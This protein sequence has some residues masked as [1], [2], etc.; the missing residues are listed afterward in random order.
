MKLS[1]V[2]C[3]YNCKAEYLESCVRSIR[4]STLDECDYEILLIDDG[5]EIDYTDIIDKYSLRCIKTE[6]GG[7]LAARTLGVRSVAGEY[8]TF[9]DSDDTVSV[10]Y[11]RPMLE[12]LE[13]EGADIVYNDWAFHSARVRHLCNRDKTISSDISCEDEDVLAM[14]TRCGGRQHSFYVLWNKMYKTDLLLR[15][16]NE[17]DR[18]APKDRKYNYSEDALINFFAHK[19]AKKARNL[20]T[21]YY[22]YRIH[23]TQSVVVGTREKLLLQIENMA[24]TLG[25]MR[26]N[27]GEH[28][29]R[30]RIIHDIREWELMMSRAHYSHALGLGFS[31]LYKTI[32]EKYNVDKL[33]RAT[34]KDGDVYIGSRVIAS[35]IDEIDECLYKIWS[36]GESGISSVGLSRYTLAVLDYMRN[37]GRNISISNCGGITIPRE[38]IS[39]KRRIIHSYPVSLLGMLLFPKGSKIRAFLKRML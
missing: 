6:N 22:F 39:T 36:N 25:V 34:L 37:T 21:G 27:V 35:N 29:M 32:K 12:C 2:I 8:I 19:W 24:F 16:I 13:T 20:H 38:K 9:V 14:F 15:A 5:S 3:V 23:D 10:N 18:L 28:T 1:V 4:R 30:D 17:V 26:A 31:D 7:I 11:H 33:K